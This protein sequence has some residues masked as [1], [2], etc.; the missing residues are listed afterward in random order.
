[1]RIA[2]SDIGVRSE[3]RKRQA[4]MHVE[5]CRSMRSKH[6]ITNTGS[7]GDADMTGNA[8][9]VCRYRAYGYRMRAHRF[10]MADH[11]CAPSRR[12]AP[13]IDSMEQGEGE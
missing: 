3:E 4:G 1:M 12:L 13:S 8:F 10:D 6:P 5:E 7:C 11:L 2:I 9:P